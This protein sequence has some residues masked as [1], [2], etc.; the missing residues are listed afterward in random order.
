LF[1]WSL[2]ILSAALLA[3]PGLRR[4]AADSTS[5]KAAAVFTTITVDTADDDEIVNGNCTLREAIQ[6]A[7]TNAAVDACPAGVAGLDE[8]VFNLGAGTPT[9]TLAA[10]LPGIEEPV[11]INGATGGA[12]RVELNGAGLAAEGLVIHAGS[13][14]R[15]LVINRFGGSAIHLEGGG[16]STIKNCYLGTD[17]TGTIDLG[18]N[19]YGVYINTSAN[20]TIGGTTAGDRNIISG[21][22]NSG[23]QIFDAAATGNIVSGNYIGVDATGSVDLGNEE[24]GVVVAAPNNMIGGALA[25]ARNI[26]SGNNQYGIVIQNTGGGGN[27]KIQGNYIGA[28]AAGTAA[29]GN[30]VGVAVQDLSNN[31]I[32]GTA[33]GE[34]NLISGN[35][36][37]GI[38]IEG[39]G[40]TGNQVQ[41]NLIGTDVTGAADVGN[42]FNGVFIYG[43]AN[44]NTVGGIASGARNLISGNDGSGIVLR[45]SN[46]TVQ[47]NYI[48]T[49]AAGTGDLGNSF[50][51][52]EMG[53]GATNNL[54][55][56]PSANARN[57]VSGND[58]H[59]IYI[60]NSNG[61]TI[62]NNY[63]G[64]NAAG[65]AALGNQEIGIAIINGSNNLIGGAGAGN[66]IADN[67]LGIYLVGNSNSNQ[68][69]GNFIGTN[70]TGTA[71]LANGAGLFMEFGAANNQIGGAAAGEGNL[72]SGNLAYGVALVLSPNNSI[73]GNL[74]GTSAAGTAALGNGGEGIVLADSPNTLIGG[75]AAGARNIISGNGAT[76]I[77]LLGCQAAAP[78]IQV[79]GNIIGADITGAVDL[80]NAFDGI[81]LTNT[82]NTVIGGTTSAARN[83]ISG[84]GFNGIHLEGELATGNLIQGNYV[85][86]N[87]AGTADLGNGWL[88]IVLNSGA[89]NNLI[90]GPTVAARNLVSGNDGNSIVLEN[91][92]NNTVQ[93]NYIG[94][95]ITGT[96][97]LGNQ[98]AGLV[99]INGA[100]NQLGGVG[101]GNLIS[102]NIVGMQI[103][104]AS[105]TGNQVQ[106]NYFGTTAAGATALLNDGT[107][108]EIF[109]GA[110]NNLIGGTT[111][112]AG[113]VIPNGL[114][115]GGAGAAGNQVQGNRIGTNAAGTAVLGAA[116]H[117]IVVANAINTI[118]GGT[119]PGARNLIAGS[120]QNGIWILNGNTTGTQV[121]GNYIGT[122]ITGTVDLGNG[123]FGVEIEHSA[124]NVI[125]GTAAG[126]GN[127]IS[128][129]D[130]WGVQLEG[131]FA[132]GN[133]VQGNF[134]GTN[135]AGNSALPNSG[136]GVLIVDRARNNTIGGVVAGAGN[137]ICFNQE[138]GVAILSISPTTGNRILGNAIFANGLLGIDLSFGFPLDSVTANDAGDG[139]TGPN[140]LQNFPVLD[141]ITTAGTVS[142]SLDSAAGNTA[143][144]VR[145]EFFANAACDTSGSGEGEGFLGA[146]SIGAPG[147]FTFNYT[148][149]AGKNF[150]TATA[151]DAN[152]NTS[153]FS[154]CSQQ[155]VNDPPTI[156]GATITVQKGT[157]NSTQQ[158]ATVSDANQPAL[159]LTVKVNGGAS[160]TSSGVTVSGLSV[161]NAGNVTAIVNAT[162]DAATTPP[163]TFT[164]TVTDNGSLSANATLTVNVTPNAKPELSYSDR[165]VAVGGSLT[166]NP[167]TGPSDNGTFIV[168][169]DKV[170]PKTGITVTVHPVTSVVS[171]TNVTK[172]DTYKIDINI[173][174]NC[175]QKTSAKFEVTV[176]TSALAE[177]NTKA[178]A[179]K[180]DF[181]GDGKS[182]LFTWNSE[183]GGWRIRRSS[184]GEL[185]V[186][187]WGVVG[188]VI[189]P[190]DYDGDLKADIAVW[191][192]ADG[193][194]LIKRSSDG[195]TLEITLG[196]RGDTPA[197]G[198]YDGDGQTDVAL[199]R[200]ATGEWLIRRSSDGEEQRIAFGAGD[201]VAAP[202]DY[203]GD[204][205]WDL[206]LWRAAD[207]QW[208]IKLSGN[209]ER[210]DLRWGMNGDAPVPAD[211][212]GDGKTDIAVWRGQIG[213]WLIRG[214]ADGEPRVV[215][216][217][218]L[219]FGDAPAPGDYDGDGKTDA[220]V[221]RAV[222]GAWYIVHGASTRRVGR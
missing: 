98:G 183:D 124:N 72:I 207:G 172:A 181:D 7:N 82:N 141:P 29:I 123:G 21:N 62:Q 83:L 121:L 215:W 179:V 35:N 79:L 208:L 202:G 209:D 60:N 23:V 155:P 122:D 171:I 106:G 140:K 86:T 78:N 39:A 37:E 199:W 205:K 40:A 221:R 38:L 20:N 8:I 45:T 13:T 142:G 143:Y 216:C 105:A 61:H 182:D 92:S 81:A 133:L 9:I 222:E 130:S 24:A 47:G 59:G 52:V 195:E 64:I 97:D 219:V 48:G 84:N 148:P 18:N 204:G 75:T 16:G 200:A 114:T 68:I 102:G 6:A 34:G 56:G 213:A 25:G 58:G 54:I 177:S 118:I 163:R 134:V 146:T 55:G 63:V 31:F 112:G 22:D 76:G 220:A 66:L 41:G 65:T 111:N 33:A 116:T 80:G 196:E 145:I 158:V 167:A 107:D 27:N 214:G 32:G 164:L 67:A 154:A 192:A 131:V 10:A 36:E 26:I 12:T 108:V 187:V 42:L 96:L 212:D 201:E 128:G 93:N 104:G 186:E 101:A 11:T 50:W 125:G 113:N 132:A 135:A 203:D 153:E 152:G 46:N 89:S 2:I 211:Y 103:L 69:K 175:H 150:I 165:T 14:I 151:T 100:N 197:P 94:T 17:A 15:A 193:H 191:R 138:A 28:N 156:A 190:A 126:A 188:D 198:D 217:G 30:K 77:W 136:G 120:S 110:S 206:A 176:T 210:L 99:I 57:V 74:I 160:A 44:G 85:G 137:R 161:D 115:I 117:G 5:A 184:D 168:E 19:G 51:G 71:A 147:S 194:W 149:V 119:T 129:N 162:C 159:T 3:W 139:D 180:H 178:K 170:Q 127:L 49:N 70:A 185:Q 166:V 144:P 73:Q 189:V 95:D 90:G 88:G 109:D 173:E 4:G 53:D 91:A 157:V 43:G 218:A 169:F 87:A 1:I 174:D